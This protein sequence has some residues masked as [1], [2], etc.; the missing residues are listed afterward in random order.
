MSVLKYVLSYFHNNY[1]RSIHDV[2]SG[3][4]KY[5]ATSIEQEYGAHKT[6]LFQVIAGEIH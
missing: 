6:H 5:I 3:N 1:I 2:L 4:V